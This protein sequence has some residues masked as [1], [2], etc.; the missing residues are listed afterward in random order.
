MYPALV[1]TPET[2]STWPQ[3][4]SLDFSNHRGRTAE[5]AKS[6]INLLNRSFVQNFY[7]KII[8][9]CILHFNVCWWSVVMSFRISQTIYFMS[10]Y[11]IIILTWC[12]RTVWRHQF[13]GLPRVVT[14]HQQDFEGKKPLPRTELYKLLANILP[15]SSLRNTEFERYF[16]P[17]VESIWKVQSPVPD[18]A[19]LPVIWFP[20]EKQEKTFHQQSGRH[21]AQCQLVPILHQLHDEILNALLGVIIAVEC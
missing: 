18:S 14:F 10:Q 20:R 3:P 11:I 12:I 9:F 17:L 2:S 16:P 15:T 1:H 5:L 19:V 6:W 7:S 4:G 13:S 8:L 21:R